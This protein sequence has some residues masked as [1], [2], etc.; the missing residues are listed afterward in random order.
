MNGD[1]DTPSVV[2]PLCFVYVAEAVK[3]LHARMIQQE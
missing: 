1:L 2:F 3:C